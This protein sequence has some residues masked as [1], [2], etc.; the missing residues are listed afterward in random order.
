MNG[1]P[2][3]WALAVN[4]MTVWTCLWLLARVVGSVV[5]V[6]L[7]EE[8]AF[9]G[10]FTRRLI[11]AD[12][13]TVP[14]GLYTWTYFAVSSVAFGVL[15]DR[16]L[17]GTMAG[18]LYAMAYCRRGSLCDAVAAHATTNALLSADALI[19]GNWSLFS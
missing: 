16:W 6:P 19:S 2:P 3:R 7:A 4:P 13:D 9:R 14:S 10:F 11:S 5:T 17:E 18:M 1:S 15:H 12:F 8:V